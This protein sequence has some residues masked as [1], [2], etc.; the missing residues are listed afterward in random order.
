[1]KGARAMKQQWTVEEQLEHF[2]LRADERAWIGENDPHNQLGKAVLLKYF[3]QEGR[4]PH[5]YK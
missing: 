4:F 2:T 1:M 5:G 3:Q